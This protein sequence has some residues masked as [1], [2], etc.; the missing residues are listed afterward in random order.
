MKI[1]LTSSNSKLTAETKELL[2]DLEGL[3]PGAEPVA[4]KGRSFK[5]FLAEEVGDEEAL[6]IRLDQEDISR[7]RLLMIRKDKNGD[8]TTSSYSIVSFVLCRRLNGAVDSGHMPELVFSNFD[9]SEND[10]RT[11]SDIE[12]AFSEESPDFEGRQVVSFTKKRGF[13][14]CRK[15]RYIIRVAE[16][17]E[18][19]KTVRLEEIGPRLSLKLQAVDVNENYI[20][21]HTKNVKI[22]D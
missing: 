20:F 10:Q 15:H 9:E 5:V 11:V 12:H 7:R 3:F 14:L 17:D 13:I 2:L 8:I 21:R 19:N 16:A 1:L 22:K 6:I 18:E 4:R